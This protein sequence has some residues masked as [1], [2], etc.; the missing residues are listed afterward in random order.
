[1]STEI[2]PIQFDAQ[3]VLII[4]TVV[5]QLF[6]TVVTGVKLRV[7][8]RDCFCSVHPKNSSPGG[9]STASD[10][11]PKRDPGEPAPPAAAAAAA[12]DN[13]KLEVSLT[14]R[15]AAAVAAA[16]VAAQ[17]PRMSISE[18]A[19]DIESGIRRARTPSGDVERRGRTPSC[20]EPASPNN[21]RKRSSVPPISLVVT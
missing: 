8:C 9:S 19:D 2:S 20:S 11:S 15:T 18:P 16:V 4:I 5:L 21:N 6:Q 13:T 10:T 3:F 12:V 1:M 17:T 7:R 14:P